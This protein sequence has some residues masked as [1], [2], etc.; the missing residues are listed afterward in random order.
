MIVA[1]CSHFV[2]DC[3][4]PVFDD[5]EQGLNENVFKDD[6]K[7]TLIKLTADRFFTLRLF[8]YRKRY[9][10]TVVPLT[11]RVA[12]EQRQFG[13]YDLA[14]PNPQGLIIGVIVPVYLD[15][16]ED[17]GFPVAKIIYARI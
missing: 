9:N 8:T 7:S 3:N 5:H 10:D 2:M 12:R 16:T 14:S 4:C 15:F 1:V 11:A 13:S 6:Q 17:N